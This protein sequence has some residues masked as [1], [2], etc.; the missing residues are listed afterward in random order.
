MKISTQEL[1][2]I[3]RDAQLGTLV[4]IKN[5]IEHPSI[6]FL[7]NSHKHKPASFCKELSRYN[8]SRCC[9]YY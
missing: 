1:K 9:A 8:K 7:F 2:D 6:S 4:P 3:L 5:K